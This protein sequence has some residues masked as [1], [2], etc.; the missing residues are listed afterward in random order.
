MNTIHIKSFV[1]GVVYRVYRNACKT[2]KSNDVISIQQVTA[3]QWEV[4]NLFLDH[5]S[6]KLAYFKLAKAEINATEK[7]YLKQ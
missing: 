2:T 6:L 5:Y 1:V 3:P 4:A 7:L